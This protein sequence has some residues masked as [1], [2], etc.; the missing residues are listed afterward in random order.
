MGWPNDAAMMDPAL[1]AL[2]V[3]YREAK[4]DAAYA[5]Y[6]RS[7]I[8]EPDEWGKWRPSMTRSACIPQETVPPQYGKHAPDVDFNAGRAECD[9]S[10]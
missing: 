2:T 7:P 6:D 1:N 8:D 9:C 5:A 3:R 4:I 10:G